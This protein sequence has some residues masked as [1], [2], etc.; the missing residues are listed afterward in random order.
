MVSP[1]KI[2]VDSLLSG[3]TT[4]SLSD[5]RKILQYL[6]TQ[7]GMH[8]TTSLDEMRGNAVAWHTLFSADVYL[9]N[10]EQQSKRLT[11]KK[12]RWGYHNTTRAKTSL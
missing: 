8:V 10:Q 9:W 2:H 11:S 3:F 7:V 4:Q 6:R 12:N 1:I 5:A